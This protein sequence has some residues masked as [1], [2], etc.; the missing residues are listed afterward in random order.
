MNYS[1]L[2]SQIAVL[3]FTAESLIKKDASF[4]SFAIYSAMIKKTVDNISYSYEIHN[5]RL[6]EVKELNSRLKAISELVRDHC[7]KKARQLEFL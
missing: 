4:E 1:N 3:F 7:D 6:D 5:I 2:L